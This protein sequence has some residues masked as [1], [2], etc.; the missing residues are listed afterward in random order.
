[1]Q[2]CVCVYVCVHVCECACVHVLV[3]YM[4]MNENAHRTHVAP[5][6]SQPPAA[7]KASQ[8]GSLWG[9]RTTQS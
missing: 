9:P 8:E 6:P 1:M 5:H 3:V 2:V 4:H 7:A